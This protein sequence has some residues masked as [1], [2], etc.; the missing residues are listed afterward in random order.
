MLQATKK[1]RTI[2]GAGLRVELMRST[3]Y[4][5]T[6]PEAPRGFS[7]LVVRLVVAVMVRNLCA[8]S[9]R[10]VNGSAAENRPPTRLNRRPLSR[11][12]LSHEPSQPFR[13]ARHR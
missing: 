2:R 1:P 4:A 5:R 3:D 9:H 13:T 7:V 6:P 10:R 12:K 8:R 11:H